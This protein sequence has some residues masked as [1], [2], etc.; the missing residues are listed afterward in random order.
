MG[1]YNKVPNKEMNIHGGRA[2]SH[3]FETKKVASNAE[4]NKNYN[5][6]RNIDLEIIT[7]ELEKKDLF[8]RNGEIQLE[9]DK[10]NDKKNEIKK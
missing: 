4:L 6:L 9:R 1:K 3:L 2:L 5:R 8:I 10:K 7:L